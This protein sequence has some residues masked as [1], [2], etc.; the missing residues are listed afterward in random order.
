MQTSRPSTSSL[1]ERF[2]SFLRRCVRVDTRSLAV[3]RILMGSLVIV[4]L[5]L[6]SRNFHFFYTEEGVVPQSIA[7]TMTPDNAVSVYFLT[8]DT[9]AIAGLFVLQA[10]IALFLIA[11]YKTRVATALSFLFVVSLDHHNP[12]VLSYADILY[13]LLFFW[14]IFVPLGERWSV[15]AVHRERAPRE[16][17][18]SIATFLLLGQMVVMYF[19][20][21]F[22]KLQ[23]EMW[24]GGM[25]TPKIIGIDEITFLLGDLMRELPIVALQMGGLWWFYI[26][27]ISPL[28]LLLGGRRRAMLV[29]MFLGGHASFALTM[30]IGQFPYVAIVGLIP[31]LQAQVWADGRAL[32]S[33]ANVDIDRRYGSVRDRL[34]RFA[35]ALPDYTWNTRR[36]RQAKAAVYNVSLG[37]VVLSLLIVV[38][39]VFVQVGVM[40]EATDHHERAEEIQE[41]AEEGPLTQHIYSASL[42]LGVDQPSWSVFAPHPRTSDRYYVFPAKTTEGERIDVYNDRELTFDRPGEELQK[43]HSTYRERFYMN[44]VRRGG[45]RTAVAP[46]LAE[47]LCENWEGEDGEQL[48][49]V[50]MYFIQENITVETIDSPDDREITRQDQF[51]LHGCGDNEPRGID[52]PQLEQAG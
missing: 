15:D 9:T 33:W 22:H 40:G 43:Q 31:F 20:N 38:S 13:R 23:S 41:A 21:G 16:S 42:A 29:L 12:L 8:T 1:F 30:R 32:L 10:L 47:H 3:F 7:T 52:P 36:G 35:S 44:S 14:A 39:S 51:Y 48:T 2:G 28:L 37:V 11:G 46:T 34:V 5:L 18:A 6:R 25:A 45:D 24:R 4:D 19:V 26:L 27:L 50:N 49:H 17:V